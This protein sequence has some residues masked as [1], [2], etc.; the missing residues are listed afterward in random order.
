V[1]RIIFELLLTNDYSF[2]ATYRGLKREINSVYIHV[3]E[4]RIL[5][6]RNNETDSKKI[7]LTNIQTKRFKSN[8]SDK[9]THI[10]TF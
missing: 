1:I 8:Q 2:F 10:A 7:I 4:K 6:Q 5:Q 3:S 9:P